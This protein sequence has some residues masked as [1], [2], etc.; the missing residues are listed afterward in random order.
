MRTALSLVGLFHCIL[1]NFPAGGHIW[2]DDHGAQHVLVHPAVLRQIT[3]ASHNLSTELAPRSSDGGHTLFWGQT[4]VHIE[5]YRRVRWWSV[6]LTHTGRGG[7]VV[8]VRGFGGVEVVPW[9]V[10]TPSNRNL[11][12]AGHGGNRYGS[13]Q[14]ALCR[15]GQAR[16]PTRAMVHARSQQCRAPWCAAETARTTDLFHRSL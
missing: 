8:G 1:R 12:V 2:A 5:G 6:L 9:V 13:Q 14:C 7:R 3:L 10:K 4:R 11:A 15:G 16:E